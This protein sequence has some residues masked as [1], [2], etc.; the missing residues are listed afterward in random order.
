MTERFDDRHPRANNIFY[1]LD[2]DTGRAFWASTD[3][4][5]DE[6][7]SQ[8]LPAGSEKAIL[9]V[10]PLSFRQFLTGPAPAATLAAPAVTALDDQTS[11]GVRTLRL[12]ITSQ[13]SA[14]VV[15]IYTDQ[16]ALIQGASINGQAIDFQAASAGAEGGGDL[17]GI[18]YY[19]F[20]AEGA[21]LILKL[22]S[23]QPLHLR[24]EDRSFGLPEIQGFSYT[25]RPAS[26]MPTP[27]AYSDATLVG[28]SFTF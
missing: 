12:R 3:E 5:P 23:T 19:A 4:R 13:R 9:P 16:E 17:W 11:N 28:K 10:Y 27:S 8:F 22:R 26:M 24:V 6:W 20:P 2:A 7:T 21:E 18:N 1:G 25:A 14:P 15:S